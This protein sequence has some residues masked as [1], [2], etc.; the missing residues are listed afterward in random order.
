MSSSDYIRYRRVINGLVMLDKFPRV[1]TNTQYTEFKSISLE[2][3]IQPVNKYDYW[4]LRP[5]EARVMSGILRLNPINCPDFCDKT[6]ENLRPN[7]VLQTVSEPTP[8][9]R[10]PI[11]LKWIK[12][13]TPIKPSCRCIRTF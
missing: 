2:K 9:P 4:R 1:L 6:E 13:N 8:A 12:Q 7:V 10:A 11:D 5:D 3:S